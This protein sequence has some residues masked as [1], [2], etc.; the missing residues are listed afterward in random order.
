[1]DFDSL[2]D[3]VSGHDE[4]IEQCVEKI[5]GLIAGGE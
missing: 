2:K 5:E 4:Q 3:K 1:M